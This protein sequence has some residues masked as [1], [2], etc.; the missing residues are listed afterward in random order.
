MAKAFESAENTPSSSHFSPNQQTSNQISEHLLPERQQLLL[1]NLAPVAAIDP[2]VPLLYEYSDHSRLSEDLSEYIVQSQE[3]AISRH[4]KFVIAI[5]GG[6]LPKLLTD[7]LLKNSRVKWESWKVFFAD[8]RVVPLEHADSNFASAMDC[9]L[10]KAPI[11]RSQ[12]ISIMSLPPEDV[13]F[14]DMTPMISS[15]YEAQ[16][17]DEL[18]TNATDP[19]PRFDLILLGMGEDGHTCSLFPS[20]PLLEGRTDATV[21]WIDDSPKPPKYRIT[22]TLPVINAAHDLAFVCTGGGKSSMLAAVLEE[23]QS[24]VRPASLIRLKDRPLAWFVDCDAASKT[25]H[26]REDWGKTS[27]G[28]L[29][30]LNFSPPKKISEQVITRDQDI[31]TSEEISNSKMIS[32]TQEPAAEALALKPNTMV[33]S[34]IILV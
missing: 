10:S 14:A 4:Q 33:C 28:L 22:L 5:S 27:V 2:S 11:K 9:F 19:I 34:I 13:D 26:R 29:S 24:N 6:S 12:I 3:Q 23:E 17:L 15:I 30:T 18:E 20:H 31:E 16:I 1:N 8:E 32:E 25:T 21:A 7:G